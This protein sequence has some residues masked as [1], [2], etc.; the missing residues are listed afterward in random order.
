VLFVILPLGIRTHAE[1]GSEP[2]PGADAGAPANPNMKRKF[3][4]TT[5]VAAIVLAVVFVVVEFGLI[6][7]PNLSRW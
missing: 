5:W 6:P 3:V 4:T 7:L 1:E 2:F